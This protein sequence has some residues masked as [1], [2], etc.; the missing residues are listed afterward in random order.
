MLRGTSH[1]L[2]F[3]LDRLRL[4]VA[5]ILF[6]L[7]FG[8]AFSHAQI[9]VAQNNIVLAD[10]ILPNAPLPMPS[11][12]GAAIPDAAPTGVSADSNVQQFFLAT[13]GSRYST[14][15]NPGEKR[16]PFTVGEKFIYSA[17]ESVDTEEFLTVMVS[18][19]FNHLIDGNPH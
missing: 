6:A 13:S 12:T 11:A 17:R 7:S 3:S 8:V 19:G 9:T 2:N 15:L 14:V 5:C 4:R 18:S 1:P 10:A 16:V